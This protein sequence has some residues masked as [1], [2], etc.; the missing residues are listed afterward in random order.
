MNLADFLGIN[1]EASEGVEIKVLEAMLLSNLI[2]V[3]VKRASQAGEL[4]PTDVIFLEEL[5]EKFDGLVSRQCS[6][7]FGRD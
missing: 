7:V 2:Q 1:I 6:D 4:I 3:E 5:R